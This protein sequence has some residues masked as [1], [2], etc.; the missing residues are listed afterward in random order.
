[1]QSIEVRINI[2]L[3]HLTGAERRRDEVASTF[4][5]VLAEGTA[6][7]VLAPMSVFV[8]GGSIPIGRHTATGRR[9]CDAFF[10]APFLLLFT[11]DE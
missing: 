9:R 11:C 7:L 8:E 2:P 3:E 1:M 10:S 6:L 5:S 4:W